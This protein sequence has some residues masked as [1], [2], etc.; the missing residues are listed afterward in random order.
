MCPRPILFLVYINDLH[1]KV[2]SSVR[3]FADDTAAYLA[4]TKLAD[5]Q[6]L[7]EDLDA[8]QQ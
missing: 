1:E 2:K 7:Q 4:I 3:L 8:L 6:Q 5:G